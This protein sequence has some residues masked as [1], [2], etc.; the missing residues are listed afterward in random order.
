VE[1]GDASIVK[2]AVA[3]AVAAD[4]DLLNTSHRYSPSTSS[5]RGVVARQP[6]LKR[7]VQDPHHVAVELV[8]RQ[9]RRQRVAG[10][11]QQ[12]DLV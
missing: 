1:D 2:P 12:H 9:Q 10:D 3:V 8:R 6:Q 11:P 4:P 7:R 5:T